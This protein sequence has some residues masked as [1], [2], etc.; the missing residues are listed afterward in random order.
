MDEVGHS[1]E[2]LGR[3]LEAVE[4]CLSTR[5]GVEEGGVREVLGGLARQALER[6]EELKGRRE[7]GTTVV[8][9]SSCYQSGQ[10]SGQPQLGGGGGGGGGGGLFNLS[11]SYS[12]DHTPISSCSY[13]FAL[14]SLYSFNLSYSYPI[15]LSSYEPIA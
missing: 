15:S 12:F 6:A 7:V 14:D 1:E 13:S 8:S 2:A 3:Y 10:T 11:S 9:H 4:L 5:E